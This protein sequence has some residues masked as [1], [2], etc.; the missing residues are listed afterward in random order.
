MEQRYATSPEQIPGMDTAE[1]RRRY[2]VPGLFVDDE[3]NAVYTHH[4]RVV[5]LGAKPV[6]GPVALPTFPEIR[7]EYFLEHREAGVVN[8]GGSGTVT[9]DGT[10]YDLAHG[11]CL[12]LGRGARDVT[13]ASA[14]A[15]SPARFYVVSA[16]AHTAYPTTLVEAGHGTVRELGDALTSNRRTLNQYIH[17]NGVRSCQVVMGVTT[18]HPGSM[19]NT[20]PAHTHDRRME[21]YLYFDLPDDARVVHLLG[22]PDETRHLVVGNEEA[23]ISPSWSVHSGVGTA[24]YSFVW[25]MAGE[26]QSFDDMD[27]FPITDMR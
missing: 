19:W 2:L 4:D 25:A 23:I 27:G 8:V 10:T 20:M 21:A 22:R 17:E 6:T 24:S 14:D 26:N 13:F 11:S 9:V 16:P 18:L 12:Y 7:S 1:L 3:A 5:L 15:T